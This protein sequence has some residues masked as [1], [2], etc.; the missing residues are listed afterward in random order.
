MVASFTT[1]RRF[2]GIAITLLFCLCLIGK[3]AGQAAAPLVTA[4]SAIG[5]HH[6]TGST[7]GSIRQT[8]IDANGDW[9][10]VD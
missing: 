8:A 3:A 9:L 1:M 10:V 7:W 4:T 6:D 2:V 5:L